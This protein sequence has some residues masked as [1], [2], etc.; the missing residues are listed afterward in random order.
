M[1]FTGPFRSSEMLEWF[2]NGYFQLSLLLRRERDEVYVKLGDL[3]HKC[4]K[5]PFLPGV[6][7]PVLK[8][9]SDLSQQQPPPPSLTQPD[10]LM[11]QYHQ[12][13]ILQKQILLR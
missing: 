11:Q 3:M 9:D 1:L 4:G 2:M 6:N 12:Y 13:Q 5:V 8:A 10:I 7:F